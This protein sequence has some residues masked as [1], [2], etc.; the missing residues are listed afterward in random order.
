[1]NGWLLDTNVLSELRRSKPDPAVTTW[2]EL[3]P[4]SSL[5]VS[6]VSLAEIRYG[7][8]TA[9]EARR[10]SLATWLEAI[11]EWVGGDNVIGVDEDTLVEWR[12]IIEASR[13]TG[14]PVGPPDTLIAATAKQHQLCIAS[15]N[16]SELGHIDVAIFNPW[17]N[18]LLMPGHRPQKINGVMTLDQVEAM[19]PRMKAVHIQKCDRNGDGVYTKS[20]MLCV[21]S[22]YHAMYVEN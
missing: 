11:R 8:E 4:S 13:S 18:T 7:I 21:K 10:A 14:R 15:R 22:I 20:E 16:A 1:M 12:R 2:I 6:R 19:Y 17:D 9:P 5:H 3:Q